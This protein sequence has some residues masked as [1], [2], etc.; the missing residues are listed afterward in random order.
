[1]HEGHCLRTGSRFMIM[2][3]VGCRVI[4]MTFREHKRLFARVQPELPSTRLVSIYIQ[5][6]YRITQ[7]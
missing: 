1:M 6:Q 3:N 7:A 4:R 5:N 2:Y